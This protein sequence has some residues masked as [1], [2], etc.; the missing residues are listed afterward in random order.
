MRAAGWTNLDFIRYQG[1][2]RLYT[3]LARHVVKLS[4][5]QDHIEEVAREHKIG[6]T[7]KTRQRSWG[8]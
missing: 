2:F 3:S 6:T 5:I 7:D 4:D 1:P 8:W